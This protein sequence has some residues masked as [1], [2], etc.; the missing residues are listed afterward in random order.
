[1]ASVSKARNRYRVQFAFRNKRYTI[2]LGVSRRAADDVRLFVERLVAAVVSNTSI[3]AAT[4]EW[5]AGAAMPIR[6]ALATAGLIEAMPVRSL[7]ELL[8]YCFAHT[9]NKESTLETWKK[10]RNNLIEYFGEKKDIT[11][12]TEGDVFEFRDWLQH[13]ATPKK[14]ALAPT[15]TTK[16]IGQA[17]SFFKTAARKRW[18]RANPFDELRGGRTSNP[19]RMAFVEPDLVRTLIELCTSNDMRLVLALC[20]WGGLRCESELNTLRWSEVNWHKRLITVHSPKTEAHRPLR[21]VPIFPE[22]RPYLEA[23]W[24]AAADNADYVLPR[25]SN[26]ALRSRLTKL[27][28]QAGIPPWDKLFQNMRATR[29]TELADRFPIHVVCAWIGNSPRVAHQHYLQV[30]DAHIEKAVA[31][32]EE[33]GLPVLGR[34]NPLDEDEPLEVPQEYVDQATCE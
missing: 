8:E 3:D 17:K 7:G 28:K 19:S 13:T 12:I 1:M 18:I 32:V 24:E 5:L 2:R 25:K 26:Q 21:F 34:A 22:I 30:T 15:T 23:Q 33:R 11:Q 27:L 4:A 14:K 6:Q 10:V 29:E 20:R 16:R 9:H 31:E